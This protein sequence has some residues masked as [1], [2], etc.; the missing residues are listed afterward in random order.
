MNCG[1]FISA[2]ENDEIYLHFQKYCY[3]DGVIFIIQYF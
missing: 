2:A 3:L 1:L